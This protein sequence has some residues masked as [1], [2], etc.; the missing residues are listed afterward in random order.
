MV[1]GVEKHMQIT[2]S[3]FLIVFWPPFFL[4]YNLPCSPC[5]ATEHLQLS[6]DSFPGTLEHS[7]DSMQPTTRRKGSDFQ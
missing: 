7:F 2:E 5:T 3:R 1:G 6:S 4:L